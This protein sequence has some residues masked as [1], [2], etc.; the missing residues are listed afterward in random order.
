MGDGLMSMS[1]GYAGVVGES[2]VS[3]VAATP[4]MLS[5]VVRNGLSIPRPFGGIA[6]S[7]LSASSK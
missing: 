2:S 7:G 1:Y 3:A 5:G 4:E 6:P